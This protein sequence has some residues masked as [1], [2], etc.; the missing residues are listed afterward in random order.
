MYIHAKTANYVLFNYSNG[1]RAA[2]MADGFQSYLKLADD[3]SV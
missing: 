3:A 2:L 1:Y